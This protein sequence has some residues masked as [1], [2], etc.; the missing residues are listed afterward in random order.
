M[1]FKNLLARMFRPK[2]CRECGHEAKHHDA[3]VGNTHTGYIIK[4]CCVVEIAPGPF[5]PRTWE[6]VE[7]GQHKPCRCKWDGKSKQ[8]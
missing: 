8:N 2:T 6:S 5:D 1:K 7:A 4:G 3:R